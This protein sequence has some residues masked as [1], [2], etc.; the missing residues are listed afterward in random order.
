[1]NVNYEYQKKIT[2]TKQTFGLNLI[3]IDLEHLILRNQSHTIYHSKFQNFN[4]FYVDDKRL[5]HYL[6]FSLKHNWKHPDMITQ[7]ISM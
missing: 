3:L 4:L 2:K 5:L 1:M 7:Y 6:I